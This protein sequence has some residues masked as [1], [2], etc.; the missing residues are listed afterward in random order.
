VGIAMLLLELGWGC[1]QAVTDVQ[2]LKPGA[3]KHELTAKFIKDR[4][5]N[6]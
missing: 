2:A 4:A 6:T 5:E 1:D 3:F